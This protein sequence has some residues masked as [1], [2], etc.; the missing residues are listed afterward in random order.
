MFSPDAAIGSRD[1]LLPAG[2]PFGFFAAAL[3]FHA[4]GWLL[5]LLGGEAL[6]GFRGGPGTVLAALHLFTLGVLATAAMGAS[7]Q[8]LPMATVRPVGSVRWAWASFALAVPGIALFTAGLAL[9]QHALAAAGGLL[10][11]A[12]LAV[13][14]V[15]MA[16]NLRPGGAAAPEM[17]VVRH[18]AWGALA[19]LAAAAGL[20]VALLCD[21][22]AG[23]LPDHGALA[24][25]HLGLALFGFMGMLAAGFST[26]LV[27]M[28][29]LGPAPSVR[30][31]HASAAAAEV[32][33]AVLVAGAFVPGPWPTVAAVL[34]GLAAVALHLTAMRAVLKARMRKRL[35]NAFLLIRTAWVLLP[36]ALATALLPALGIDAFNAPTVFA[37]LAVFGWLLTFLFGVLQR[38]APFLASMHA[39]VPGGRPPLVS[40]L[41][42]ERPLKAHAVLHLAAVALLVAGNLADLE[43]LARLGALSGLGGAV[44]LLIFAFA[45]RRRAL[46]AWRNALSKTRPNP[47]DLACST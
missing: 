20:G 33:L 1:R 5:L 4:A 23:F 41:T 14:A 30:L 17:R 19:A 6:V 42:P 8:L 44:A 9:W 22:R 37:V 28:L 45:V 47:G 15:L 43:V 26:I 35:G 40:A 13:F 12:G 21:L 31:G 2:V 32:G 36:V 34:C 39:T 3:A 24:G 10:A 18:Y 25:V 38:I 46:A 7:Y 29:A 11:A 27:P 16:V